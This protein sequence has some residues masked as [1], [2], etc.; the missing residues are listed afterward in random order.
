M[1]VPPHFFVDVTSAIE[2]KKKMLGYHISQIELMQHMHK[3][4]DFFG[5]VLEGNRNYGKMAGVEYAEVYWQHLGGGFQKEP[6][7]QNELS[8]FLINKMS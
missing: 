2:T 5:Y 8:E 7:V 6:Q 4:N 1:I 3:M